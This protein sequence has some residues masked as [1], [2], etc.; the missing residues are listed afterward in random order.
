MGQI[1]DQ[2]LLLTTLTSLGFDQAGEYV[3]DIDVINSVR[4]LI[5]FLMQDNKACFQIHAIIAL[6]DWLRVQSLD[7]KTL[8]R[9]VLFEFK[10]EVPTS[11]QKI[12]FHFFYNT[13]I[14]MTY[15]IQWSD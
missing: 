5:R 12:L 13:V 4:V 3:P 2:D 9:N 1:D 15:S 14:M 10:L 6:S 11:G 8:V 7:L